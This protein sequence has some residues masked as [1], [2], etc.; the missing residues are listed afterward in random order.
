[1]RPH[2]LIL[3]TLL[4]ACCW[5]SFGVLGLFAFEDGS[6]LSSKRCECDSVELWLPRRTNG[7]PKLLYY[8]EIVSN[9]VVHVQPKSNLGRGLRLWI[10]KHCELKLDDGIVLQKD[11]KINN[12]N[13]TY[14]LVE[15]KD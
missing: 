13:R 10:P 4:F 12:Q 11:V 2:R 5:L 8:E 7:A 1:M 3:T 14:Q 9:G 6:V 15:V